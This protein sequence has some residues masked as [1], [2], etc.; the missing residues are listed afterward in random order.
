MPL[1]VGPDAG[2]AQGGGIFNSGGT[3]S[4][5]NTI[6]AA[7]IA[8][9][10]ST[11]PAS[12]IGP[13]VFGPIAAANHDLVGNGAGSNLSPDANGNLVGTNSA[14]INPDL[15]TLADN[16]GQTETLAPAPG[17]PAIAAGTSTGLPATDQRD[18]L[19]TAADIGAFAFS[20]NGVDSP[21]PP[22]VAFPNPDATIAVPS[23]NEN[24][25]SSTWS[26]HISGTATAPAGE[27][28]NEV[29][30]SIEFTA[31]DEYPPSSY[32]YPQGDEPS[33]VEYWNGTAFARSSEV[34]VTATGTN[35]WSLS[36]PAKKLLLIY[37][38][39]YTIHVVVIDSDGSTQSGA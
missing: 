29:E 18:L 35:A 1:G 4:A 5:V 32:L 2:E 3:I 36:I 26:G 27:T 7:N 24:Y 31:Q 9:N 20:T 12:E 13:D 6:I 30:V 16:G 10:F 33:G 25:Y 22:T 17:S 8:Q 28:V 15:G 21:G 39:D 23:L 37:G 19:R 38:A 34:F 11:Q 14:P